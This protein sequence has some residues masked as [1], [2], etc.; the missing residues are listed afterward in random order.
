M[1]SE[2]LTEEQIKQVMDEV[3]EQFLIPRFLQLGMDSSGEWKRNL[4][5]RGDGVI[6]GRHYTV[7]L[8]NGRQPGTYSP[9]APLKE[10]AMTKLGLDEKQATAAAFAISKTHKESGS[11]YYRQGGTTL[12]DI[13]ESR[14]CAGFIAE[15]FQYFIKEQVTLDVR[16]YLKNAL[17]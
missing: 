14:E 7:Q 16:R 9:I 3:I 10:W 6:R 11:A 13:L 15:R 8:V 12:L 4:E 17:K 2:Y 5:G 1:K